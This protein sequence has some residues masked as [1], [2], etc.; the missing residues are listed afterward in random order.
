M[1]NEKNGVLYID[2]YI[3]LITLFAYEN[4]SKYYTVNLRNSTT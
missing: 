1:S 2:V 4:I 3:S